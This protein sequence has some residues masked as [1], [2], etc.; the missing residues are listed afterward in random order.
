MLTRPLI[1][2][3]NDV[4]PRVKRLLC[5]FLVGAMMLTATPAQAR[6]T[7]P[8]SSEPNV[9]EPVDYKV[10]LPLIATADTAVTNTN[11]STADEIIIA[12]GVNAQVG[13]VAGSNTSTLRS[14]S[15]VPI[16]DNSVLS[17]YTKPSQ[18]R[19]WYNAAQQRWD[20]L[21]PKH[22]GGISA[23]DHYILKDVPGTQTFTE[24]ELEDRDF[25]RPDAFWDEAS[26]KLYVLSSH[27]ESSEFWRLGYDA[28]GD[29][30]NFEVGVQGA[31][32]EVF[33]ITHPDDCIGGNSPATIYVTPNG[34]VWVAAM[35]DAD[36][37]QIQHSQ[38]GGATW[39]PE[40][41]TLDPSA[42]LG[43]TTWTHFE[44]QDATYV[45]LF[46][47][48]NGEFSKPTTNH[49][50]YIDQD[51][52]PT[53]AANWVDDSSNIPPPTGNEQSDDHVGAARDAAG[54][55]YFVTKT[56]GG[57]PTDPLIKLYKR[58]P[59]GEWTQYTVT[60]TQEAPEES[61]PSIVIDD[62]NREIYIYSSGAEVVGNSERQGVHK[63]AVSLDA[64][65]DLAKASFVTIF[66]GGT[67]LFTDVITPRHAV[68]STSGLVTLVHNRTFENVWFSKQEI[69]PASFMVPDVV[70]QPLADARLAVVA[71][72]FRVG[73]MTSVHS[74]T[75]VRGNIVEQDPA[76]GNRAAEGSEI[77]LVSSLGPADTP[78]ENTASYAPVADAFVDE[79]KPD[80]N[81]G[82]DGALK[83]SA[84]DDKQQVSYLRFS[85]P[86]LADGV[87]RATLR[88]FAGKISRAGV[89]LYLVA[90]NSWGEYSITW[91]NRPSLGSLLGSS[92]PVTNDSWIE[93]DVTS[94]VDGDG[95][96]SF[97]LVEVADRSEFMSREEGNAPQLIVI[98]DGDNGSTPTQPDGMGKGQN[99]DEIRVY[100]PIVTR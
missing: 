7:S 42:Q 99:A 39:L 32:V 88:L 35:K 44:N 100:L 10:F 77:N 18:S 54:N 23:S 41:I 11:V 65:D 50:W 55:Q 72:G 16:S 90:D 14:C 78:Q 82:Q 34:H 56:E 28:D 9:G 22:D 97:A 73:A 3:G 98:S 75:A 37:L 38:D 46:A 84:E 26:G 96:A 80:D 24:V 92:G 47:G 48:E 30:Y 51:A 8:N 13:T 36:G 62:N 45:G 57:G 94:A 91:N 17:A 76:G 61:R 52:D 31:G 70:G 1:W 29:S 71:A 20:A 5:L 43:V 15:A 12:S 69:Q 67:T 68:N 4:A 89:N 83:T 93:I 53:I 59:A 63:E 6:Q 66:S 49:Y 85:L 74:E 86:D 2:R 87:T 79:G 58:T 60:T 27:P 95:E 81:N 25:G 33:G 19:I 64:L 40:P 21:M